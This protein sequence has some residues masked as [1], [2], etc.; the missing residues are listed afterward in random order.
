MLT[1]SKQKGQ[2]NSAIRLEI[3]GEKEHGLGT[4]GSSEAAALSGGCK[5]TAELAP[6]LRIRHRV[7]AA[8]PANLQH[9]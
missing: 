7:S 2:I 8:Q 9:D 6:R 4:E 1:L 3:P 5:G